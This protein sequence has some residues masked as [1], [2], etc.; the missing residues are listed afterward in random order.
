[1]SGCAPDASWIL[2]SDIGNR[3]FQQTSLMGF[4]QRP[5]PAL[6]VAAMTGFAMIPAVSRHIMRRKRFMSL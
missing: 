3:H 5:S 6:L 1:V 4:T 2:P